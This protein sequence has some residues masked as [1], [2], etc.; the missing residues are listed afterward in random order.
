MMRLG[1]GF[2]VRVCICVCFE[3]CFKIAQ[4]EISLDWSWNNGSFLLITG[5]IYNPTAPSLGGFPDP[6]QTLTRF[7][8]RS[9]WLRGG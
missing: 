5:M 8:F 1:W 4:L 6:L 9:P 3:L 7:R 2:L